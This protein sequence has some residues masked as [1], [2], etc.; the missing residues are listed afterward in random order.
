MI[1]GALIGALCALMGG[2]A[3]AAD[4]ADMSALAKRD[5]ASASSRLSRFSLGRTAVP[6]YNEAKFRN[7]RAH[8]RRSEFFLD[9]VIFCGE[10]DMKLPDGSRTGWIGFGIQA[11]AMTLWSDRPPNLAY[12]VMWQG[13]IYV[14][15]MVAANVLY[16][17]GSVVESIIK[18]TPL[19]D[20]RRHAWRL[21]LF[22]SVAL[23]LIVATVFATAIGWPDSSG[24]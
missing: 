9:H 1:R 17:T 2:A 7:V 6:D 13:L 8:Y 23:P 11:V 18:P 15:Y 3:L 10:I 20:F 16:L 24:V 21:G 14:F 5:A 4:P 19:D 22:A 12:T